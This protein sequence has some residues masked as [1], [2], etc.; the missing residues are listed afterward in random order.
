MKTN[1]GGIDRSLRVVIGAI[2]VTMAVLGYVGW[3]GWV[4]VILLI[5]GLLKFCPFYT[6]L[7]KSTCCRK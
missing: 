7:G 6:L 5:T 3:W 4:G 2:L 1:V